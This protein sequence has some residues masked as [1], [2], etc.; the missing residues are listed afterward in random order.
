MQGTAN[1]HINATGTGC[2]GPD[3]GV[4]VSEFDSVGQL[5]DSSGSASNSD[6]SWYVPMH[7]PSPDHPPGRYKL[8]ATCGSNA[9]GGFVYP[10]IYVTMTG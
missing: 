2:S 4:S 1:Q 9:G 3:F 6:G 7:F 5:M 10:P 8:V